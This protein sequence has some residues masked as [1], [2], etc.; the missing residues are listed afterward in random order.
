MTRT[1]SVSFSGVFC[2]KISGSEFL[3]SSESELD[4]KLIS[5]C[6]TVL[7]FFEAFFFATSVLEEKE[8]DFGRDL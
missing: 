3:L 6:F 7:L 8:D 4:I 1:G 5:P 2:V